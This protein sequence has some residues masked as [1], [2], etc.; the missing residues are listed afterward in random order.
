MENEEWRSIRGSDGYEVSSLGNVRD[1]V[2]GKMV[3][4]GRGRG[5]FYSNVSVRYSGGFKKVAAVHRLVAFAFLGKPGPGA[6]V[7]HMDGDTTNNRAANLEYVTA[8]EN[9]LHACYRMKH[10][11]WV[12]SAKQAV[13]EKLEKAVKP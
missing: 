10:T 4:W 9:T 3:P 8:S 5:G 13:E 12:G 1:L 11:G 7:N 6:M 2:R